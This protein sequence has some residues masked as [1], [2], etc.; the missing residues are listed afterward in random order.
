MRQKVEIDVQ[1]TDLELFQQLSIDDCW[2]D[3]ELPSV[4]MYLAKN[5]KMKVPT[6]WQ[7]TFDAL[8]NEISNAT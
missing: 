6:S 4:F 7:P 5:R 8:Y 3:A 1:K 2:W